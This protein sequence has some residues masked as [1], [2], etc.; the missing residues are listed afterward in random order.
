MKTI[1]V[2][3]ELLKWALE[4]SGREIEQIEGKNKDLD[5]AAWLNGDKQPTL[6]Q[7]ETFAQRTYTSIPLLLLRTP[8]EEPMPISDFRLLSDNQHKKPTRTYWILSMI[9]N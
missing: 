5:L 9:A 1:A 4:L 8:I 3:K 7:L 6:K 2:N